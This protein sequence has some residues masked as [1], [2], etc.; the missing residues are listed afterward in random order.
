MYDRNVG[1]SDNVSDGNKD[2][3]TVLETGEQRVLII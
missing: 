2:Y 3:V 1:N